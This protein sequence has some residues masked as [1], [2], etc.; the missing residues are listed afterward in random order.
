MATLVVGLGVTGRAVVAQLRSRGIEVRAIDDAPSGA[1]VDA[2]AAAGVELVVAPSAEQVAEVLSGC[3]TVV[4]SPGVPARHPIY[5]AAR[6][7]GAEIV[8]EI[9]LAWRWTEKPIV[10][11]TGTN[12]KTTVTTVVTEMLNESGVRAIAAGNIGLPLIEAVTQDAAVFVAEVSSFQLEYTAGFHP[13]VGTWLN[14]AED[15]LDW[16]PTM[17]HYAAAKER[18]W[19]NQGAGDFAIANADDA[20]ASAALACAPTDVHITF[21]TDKLAQWRITVEDVRMPGG[22]VFVRADQ[23]P[24]SLPH[25][26]ANVAAAAATAIA[27]G[28]SVDAC[29][30]VATTFAG[31]PHRVQLVAHAGGVRWYDDSKATTP[32]SVLAA[33]RGFRSVVLLAGGRN[34]GLDLS[35]LRDAAEHIKAVVAFGEAA[36]EIEDA[37]RGLR[38]VEWAGSM[39]DAVRAAASFAEEGDVVLLS[40]GCAS[41]DWYRNYSERGE[42]FVRRID[43]VVGA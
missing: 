32:A 43:E 5:T 1:A 36:Q 26:L 39:L 27:A 37:F 17:Q 2:A 33:V 13:K 6:Q 21:G 20:T 15:H 34:K 10:A 3:D 41:Y 30:H 23:L 12:G 31:L 11:I 42:D 16:H 24:R 35:V 22:E 18:I 8:S 14:F 28:A 9:E 7:H 19:A 38:P 25:D 4:V 29:R 40:P